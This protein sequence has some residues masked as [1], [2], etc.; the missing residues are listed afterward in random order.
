[1]GSSMRLVYHWVLKDAIMLC[2]ART[3]KTHKHVYRA[4]GATSY[5]LLLTRCT[6]SPKLVRQG[7]REALT[8]IHSTAFTITALSSERLYTYCN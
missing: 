3:K 8:L 7:T 4:R 2:I 6:E 1:M 5:D